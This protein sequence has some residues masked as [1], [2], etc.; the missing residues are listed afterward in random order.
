MAYL[1]KPKKVLMNHGRTGRE[2]VESLTYTTRRRDSKRLSRGEPPK[3]FMHIYS[4]HIS[5]ALRVL[6][7]IPPVTIWDN[8]IGLDS[9][10]LPVYLAQYE[11]SRR[12]PCPRAAIDEQ[13]EFDE[14]RRIRANLVGDGSANRSSSHSS[15]SSIASEDESWVEFNMRPKLHED[16]TKALE[17][18]LRPLMPPS[19]TSQDACI[20]MCWGSDEMCRIKSIFLRDSTNEV[21][22][23]EDIRQAWKLSKSK[24]AVYF[25]HIST[26]KNVDVVTVGKEY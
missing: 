13:Q 12:F 8:S 9:S 14:D 26:I 19:D 5:R 10:P 11:R 16:R 3:W 17:E 21:A 7:I 1:E 4:F 18:Y 23:W 24:W 15:S 20:L 25:S 2:D 22:V 6:R